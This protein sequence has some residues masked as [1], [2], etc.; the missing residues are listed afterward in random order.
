MTVVHLQKLQQVE[1]LIS[2]WPGTREKEKCEEESGHN[3]TPRPS[4]Q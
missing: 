4:S 1:V 2:A 3:I